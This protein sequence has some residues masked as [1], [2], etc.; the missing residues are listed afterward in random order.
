MNTY[1]QS[2]C[3]LQRAHLF[4]PILNYAPRLPFFGVG[5][6]CERRRPRPTRRAVLGNATNV[7]VRDCDLAVGARPIGARGGAH[8]LPN[9]RESEMEEISRAKEIRR[10]KMRKL[11]LG[12]RRRSGYSRIRFAD[13]T[14]TSRRLA[15][16]AS[17][18]PPGSS[19]SRQS[20]SDIA[21]RHAGINLRLDPFTKPPLF[22]ERRACRSAP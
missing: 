13:W 12:E 21:V 9:N 11:R 20:P 2:R 5:R 4:R 22:V 10:A 1:G 15:H 3:S 14:T 19:S 16:V 8:A 17:R 7:R 6:K 18:P